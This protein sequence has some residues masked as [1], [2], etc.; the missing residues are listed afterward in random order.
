MNRSFFQKHFRNNEYFRNSPSKQMHSLDYLKLVSAIFYQIF[1]F[2]KMIALLK[3]VKN[4]F[5]FHIKN[6]FHSRDIE[7]FVSFSFLSTLS[8]F[9]RKSGSGIIY[10]VMN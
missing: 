2:H 4:V 8:R 6:S 3:T 10:D 1:I 5:L 9:K 7:I